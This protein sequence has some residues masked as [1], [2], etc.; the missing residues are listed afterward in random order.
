MLKKGEK[1]GEKIQSKE[2]E[3]LDALQRIVG[4]M[5]MVVGN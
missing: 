3:W 1:K 4:S 2:V 5:G